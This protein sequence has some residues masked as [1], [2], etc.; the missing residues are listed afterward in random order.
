MSE[1]EKAR[2]RFHERMQ[3]IAVGATVKRGQV[4]TVTHQS[5]R[6]T[7]VELT[8]KR[9]RRSVAV[10]VPVCHSGPCLADVGLSSAGRAPMQRD[11]IAQ[12]GAA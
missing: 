12:G 1:G 4:W 2:K 9:G 8:L 3:E 6:E 7:S 10:N 5:R 11:L